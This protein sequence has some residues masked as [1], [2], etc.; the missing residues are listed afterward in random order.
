MK[1]LF[2][3]SCS[4]PPQVW[5]IPENGLVTAM[6]EPVVV[7][8]GH[9]K[10]VGIITWHPTA[11]NVLLSAGKSSLRVLKS[12][13]QCGRNT[14]WTRI[15]KPYRSSAHLHFT[16]SSGCDN[17]IIIWNVGTGE[18]MITLEDMHPDVIY[19]VCWNRN[20]SL[21][22]TSCKDKAV[23]VIDPR[24]E[25]IVAVSIDQRFNFLFYIPLFLLL[26]RG[27]Y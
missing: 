5:Q 17:Q 2:L 13:K 6:S 14:N 4:F 24:K 23:R 1:V 22:C 15:F 10:R 25:M 19:S 7:L 18:A 21:I 26:V 16:L 12:P 9:S 8:E 27:R 20:G 11:R 3:T